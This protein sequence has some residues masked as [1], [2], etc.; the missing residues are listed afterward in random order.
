MLVFLSLSLSLSLYFSLSSPLWSMLQLK[1]I[2]EGWF[3]GCGFIPNSQPGLRLHYCGE[4]AGKAAWWAREIIPI[5]IP[6]PPY[7]IDQHMPR[8]N[9]NN[10]DH[11]RPTHATKSFQ[12][13]LG[14]L[15]LLRCFGRNFSTII[16]NVSSLCLRRRNRVI[17]AYFLQD[18]FK[19]EILRK[20][21][22]FKAMFMEPI[23]V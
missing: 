14:M 5:I 8:N 12:K 1:A 10:R 21:E 15:L 20:L 19:P 3:V 13:Q 2:D 23:T 17:D 11:D 9:F 22:C 16:D 6:P 7:I 18:R 4:Q